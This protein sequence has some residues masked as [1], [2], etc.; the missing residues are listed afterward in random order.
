VPATR[1]TSARL[2]H[3]RL[4][5]ARYDELEVDGDGARPGDIQ[6]EASARARCRRRVNLVVRAIAHTFD[7]RRRR[8][9]GSR[10]VA[11]LI[12]H[13]RAGVG[14]RDRGRL[15]AAKGLL[16]GI[17][18]FSP[19][20]LLELATEL[21]GHPDNVAPALFGGLTI[22]WSTP[23]GP[24]HKKLIVHRGVSPLVL[25]PEHEMSTALARS[26][27]ARV[28]AARGRG[29]QRLAV[30]AARRGAHPEPRA[31]PAG[32]RGQ[33]APELPRQA[34]P[35]TDRL[36]RV[37][38]AAGHPAV[39]SGAG[40]SI[41]VLASDPSERA[42]AIR[43]VE[44]SAETR[45][46]GAAARGRLPGRDGRRR[47]ALASARRSARYA[48]VHRFVARLAAR[49]RRRRTAARRASGDVRPGVRIG[50]HPEGD[51]SSAF[52]TAARAFPSNHL[53]FALAHVCAPAHDTARAGDQL[54]W[55]GNSRDQGKGTNPVTNGTD[56]A[57]VSV[58]N[59]TRL[60]GLKV[61]ELQELAASL[62]IAGASKRRKGDLVDLISAHQDGA[63]S[64][65]LVDQALVTV[66]PTSPAPA[67]E[68][69]R[70]PPP[71]LRSRAPVDE[72]PAA[73]APPRPVR[74]PRPL[75]P[76]RLPPRPLRPS[77]RMP[78]PTPRP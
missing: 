57:D 16:A 31:A 15:M 76:S 59:R 25:V 20:D 60:N 22:A 36:I 61:A 23:E 37:L 28:G 51:A 2:R 34:M 77:R 46:A 21:E 5:L 64:P 8:A 10:L 3:A 48:P 41:L 78:R 66:E 14:R 35:E 13:G 67:E 63:E 12:P 55:V 30:G 58:A 19:D 68:A 53:H 27:A 18:E 70:R 7:A 43:L 17:V 65:A 52:P 49:G 42:D 74:P 72:A 73:E 26:P 71:R 47:R 40:P 75:R 32:H 69:P 29:V 38:R 56:H 9:V 62:G 50:P 6:V 44:E 33:A 1:R 54:S 11:T 24:R 4:A 45:V 39:V